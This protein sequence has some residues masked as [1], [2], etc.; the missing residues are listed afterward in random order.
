MPIGAALN[1]DDDHCDVTII[2]AR[3][4]PIWWCDTMSLVTS[5]LV[6]WRAGEVGDVA[7]V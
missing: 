3:K 5:G 6:V 7:P 1:W 2:S 4:A